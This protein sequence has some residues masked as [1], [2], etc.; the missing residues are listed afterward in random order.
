MLLKYAENTT[1]GLY[2][3]IALHHGSCTEKTVHEK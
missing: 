3:N 2:N 1:P